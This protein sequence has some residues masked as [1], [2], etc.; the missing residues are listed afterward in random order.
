MAIGDRVAVPAD[1]SLAEMLERIRSGCQESTRRLFKTYNPSLQRFIARRFLPGR[2]PIQRDLDSCDLEQETWT[3]FFLRLKQGWTCNGS[4][5]FLQFLFSL[6]AD[7]Y[8]D[9]YRA[10][11]VAQKRSVKRRVALDAK[12]HDQPETD[13]GPEECVDSEDERRHFLDR[14]TLDDK[15]FLLA[16][17]FGLRGSGIA[18][19]LHISRRSVKRQMDYL[20]KLWGDH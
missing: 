19:H 3:C 18:A 1:V 7:R 12:I 8:K 11:V 10:L 9:Q 16:L 20:M 15:D 4:A 17:A 5:E 2:N 6:S 14:L 13:L